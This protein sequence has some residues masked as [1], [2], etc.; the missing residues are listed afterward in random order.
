[1][2]I[3]VQHQQG[4]GLLNYIRAGIRMPA[5][6]G[7]GDDAEKFDDIE[8]IYLD[9]QIMKF[10]KL[11]LQYS[12]RKHETKE[13][14]FGDSENWKQI[15]ESRTGKKFNDQVDPEAPFK[16]KLDE[17][18]REGL[19]WTLLLM[20][21]PSSPLPQPVAVLDEI[22]WPVAR[23]AGADK[24]L[25][26]HLKLEKRKSRKI[27]WNDSKEWERKESKPLA[28]VEGDKKVDLEEAKK[29]Q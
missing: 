3:T 10:Q 4:Q 23:A 24:Q 28:L 13:I 6:L 18:E 12:H 9:E 25:A 17:D 16:M 21:H 29:A 15:V 1:M 20:S 2:E 19:Y 11:L 26:K 5:E 8:R 22:V 27:L 7:R 14:L